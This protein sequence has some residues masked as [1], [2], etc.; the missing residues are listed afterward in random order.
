[1]C[2]VFRAKPVP[3]SWMDMYDCIVPV[4][5]VVNLYSHSV[6][7]ASSTVHL[8][9]YLLKLP[10]PRQACVHCLLTNAR[11]AWFDV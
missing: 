4:E 7:V 5:C 8:A 9:S 2:A 6:H 1:M 11:A 10:G 3:K